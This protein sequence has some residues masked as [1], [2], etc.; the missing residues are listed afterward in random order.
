MQTRD[1]FIAEGADR[2]HY[3]LYRERN[4][5]DADLSPRWYLQ[6]LFG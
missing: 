4:A 5:N 2:A 3:W 6:G 1:Y